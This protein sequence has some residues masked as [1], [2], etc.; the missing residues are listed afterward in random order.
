MK[1]I[2]ILAMAAVLVGCATM[3]NLEAAEHLARTTESFTIAVLPDTQFYAD[4]RLKLSSKWGNGDLRRYFFGERKERCQ[5][6]YIS[7]IGLRLVGEGVG[8]RHGKKAES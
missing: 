7:V 1:K 2:F 5:S 8:F 3:Q 6:Y 4:T